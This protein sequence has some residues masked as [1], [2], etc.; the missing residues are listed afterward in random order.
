MKQLFWKREEKNMMSSRPEKYFSLLQIGA[1]E[2]R[3]LGLSRQRN[4][5]TGIGWRYFV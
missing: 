1:V 4:C 3:D 5:A 2:Q